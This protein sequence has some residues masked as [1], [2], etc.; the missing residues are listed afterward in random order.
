MTGSPICNEQFEQLH[1]CVIIPTYN[2]DTSLEA[3]IADVVNYTNHIIVVNDGSTDDTKAIIELFP[4]VQ[5]INYTRNA[6]KG[7]ALRKAFAYASE[8]GYR[9]AVTI[10]S[11]GQH[12]AKDLPAFL[13]KLTQEP[14]AIIIGARNMDQASVP[15]GSNF[16]N[17]FSNFWFRVETGI[18]LPDTQCGY[19]LYPLDAIN[20]MRLF[21]RK[22]EFEIEVMVRAAWNGV[23]VLSVP[24]TVYYAPKNERVSHFRPVKDFTRISILN[25][26]LVLI[27][28]LII[29]PFNFFRTIVNKEKIKRI[30]NDHFLSPHYSA[31]V[32]AFSVA[33]G[34][35]MGIIPIW[36]F[37][38]IAAIS[39]A[40][41]FDLNKPLVIIAANISIPPMIPVIIFASFKT[42]ALWMGH[43]AM[44]IGFSRSIS[45]DSIKENLW[46]YIYGSVT[47]AVLAG[48]FLG[49][50]TFIVLKLSDKK[51]VV[52]R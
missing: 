32:N 38:L 11:D 23:K 18:R 19:R 47:L 21:T 3:V 33:F 14:N 35:F 49:L 45:L 2:N 1:V 43:N 15:G 27:A 31:Q 39:L 17:R 22:F 40:I 6:G 8:K 50:L 28:F 51:R 16:G 30:L 48:A 4:F 13:D 5:L 26:V 37:Q 41:L 46:Q 36:G 24:I 9:Y 34:I 29:K 12:F 42:G 20:K 52:I 25:T 10:D 44:S 7:W